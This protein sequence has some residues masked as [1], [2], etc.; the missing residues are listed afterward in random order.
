MERI[1]S[2]YKNLQEFRIVGL[3]RVQETGSKMKMIQG[4]SVTNQIRGIGWV[5]RG[6]LPRDKCLCGHKCWGLWLWD[7]RKKAIYGGIMAD[8]RCLKTHVYR[9]TIGLDIAL[10]MYQY[11]NQF[12][13]I[14][15]RGPVGLEQGVG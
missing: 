2:F 14:D 15:F 4:S 5:G 6:F 9:A 1:D 10:E 12:T 13:G 11:C 7:C 8:N 3:K